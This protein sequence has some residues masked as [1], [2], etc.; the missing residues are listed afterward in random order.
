MESS[1]PPPAFDLEEP[2]LF[3]ERKLK[4]L[5]D[6]ERAIDQFSTALL[7]AKNQRCQIEREIALYKQRQS[8]AGIHGI[9][10]EI[11]CV[12]FLFIGDEQGVRN[13]RL[14]LV[15]KVWQALVIGTP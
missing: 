7:I 11:L 8:C 9:P 4:D 5:K 12:I 15:C 2:S 1:S 3:L 14:S 6:I 13:H 10:P